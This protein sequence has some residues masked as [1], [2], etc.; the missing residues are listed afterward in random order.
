M[1]F[2]CLDEKTQ[3]RVKDI[4]I[5]NLLSLINF[6]VRVNINTFNNNSESDELESAAAADVVIMECEL[7]TKFVDENSRSIRENSE[8]FVRSGNICAIL[9]HLLMRKCV[10]IPQ[11]TTVYRIKLLANHFERD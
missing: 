8:L 7:L 4:L 11:S 6:Y 2:R 1:N 10:M 3:P 9:P 5:C